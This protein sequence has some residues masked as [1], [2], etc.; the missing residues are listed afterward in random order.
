MCYKR[1]H[2]Q[3][4]TG[5]QQCIGGGGGGGSRRKGGRVNSTPAIA[6]RQMRSPP[7]DVSLLNNVVILYP[8]WSRRI[9]Q[10]NCI[11]ERPPRASTNARHR[12]CSPHALALPRLPCV[13][14]RVCCHQSA[15]SGIVAPRHIVP[16][17][18]D[19]P[20]DVL[21]CPP[22][23]PGHICS[24]LPCSSRWR[25]TGYPNGVRMAFVD[26]NVRF[27]GLSESPPA[28]PSTITCVVI[29]TNT[30]ALG[31]NDLNGRCN[32]RTTL[33]RSTEKTVLALMAGDGEKSL[34]GQA[35]RGD[36][37]A[38]QCPSLVRDGGNI[39]YK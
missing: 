18:I 3:G 6:R 39:T 5:A 36:H 19:R 32:L 10:A 13:M 33:A 38:K 23:L 1:Q 35:P 14:V 21:T 27:V 37:P 29:G 31:S 30:C 11:S 25:V 26:G 4:Y 16:N 28:F 34:P 15:I 20:V 17:K 8:A 7:E 24:A 12:W 22:S 2:H 9:Y